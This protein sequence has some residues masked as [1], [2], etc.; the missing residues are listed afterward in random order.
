MECL[1]I[2]AMLEGGRMGRRGRADVKRDVTREGPDNKP[3]QPPSSHIS[4]WRVDNSGAGCSGTL[5]LR[6][7]PE[8][9]E[10][11]WDPPSIL[12]P[13]KDTVQHEG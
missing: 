13:H 8:V 11:S 2:V 7:A 10:S 12:V 3:P 4:P 5:C 6:Y 1:T 9:R